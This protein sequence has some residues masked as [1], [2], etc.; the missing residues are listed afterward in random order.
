MV[1]VDEK[2]YQLDHEPNWLFE[3]KTDERM[4]SGNLHSKLKIDQAQKFIEVVPVND[5]LIDILCEKFDCVLCGENP[6]D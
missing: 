3:L 4:Y 6:L 2:H 1:K 5:L